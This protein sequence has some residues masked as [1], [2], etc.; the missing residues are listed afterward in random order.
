MTFYQTTF[1]KKSK[2]EVRDGSKKGTLFAQKLKDEREENQEIR[3][4]C[5]D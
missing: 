1:D 5:R 3:K 2:P 4:R